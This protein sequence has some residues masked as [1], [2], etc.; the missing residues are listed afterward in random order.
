LPPPNK[1]LNIS[2]ISRSATQNAFG[3]CFREG[4]GKMEEKAKFHLNFFKKGKQT[5]K[6]TNRK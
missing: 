6:Q 4:N 3:Q 1:Q 5:N 2:K